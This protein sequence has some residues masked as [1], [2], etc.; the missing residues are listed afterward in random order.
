MSGLAFKASSY[1]E[2]LIERGAIEPRP[3][4]SL[5]R[6]YD[7]YGPEPPESDGEGAIS[8]LRREA[9]P[10]IVSL[11]GLPSSAEAD[12]Y[13]ALDQTTIRIKRTS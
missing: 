9:V 8:L 12:L 1:L 5:D 11:F 10:K 7:E 3:N 13:R 6:I 2:A 4:A